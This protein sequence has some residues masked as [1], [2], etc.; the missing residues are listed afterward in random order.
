MDRIWEGGEGDDSGKEEEMGVLSLSLLRSCNSLTERFVLSLLQEASG[1][2]AGRP[3][4]WAGR[5]GGEGEGDGQHQ[6]S[7]D[8]Q[9]LHCPECDWGC[10][11]WRLLRGQSTFLSKSLSKRYLLQIPSLISLNFDTIF[12]FSLQMYIGYRSTWVMI[13]SIDPEKT[14]WS[15]SPCVMVGPRMVTSTFDAELHV[16]RFGT[17]MNR[18]DAPR[19]S[20]ASSRNSEFRIF[21]FFFLLITHGVRC[22]YRPEKNLWMVVLASHQRFSAVSMFVLAEY[23]PDM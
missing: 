6:P 9:E 23:G 12:L 16:F 4:R 14:C 15:I 20:T 19:S 21:F 7:C 13:I 5:A 11:E 10:R 3:E 2:G 18:L 22:K 8:T 17:R 1:S